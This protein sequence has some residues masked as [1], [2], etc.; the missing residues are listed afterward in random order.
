MV[1]YP[2]SPDLVLLA[3]AEENGE[4]AIV[5]LDARPGSAPPETLDTG[6]EGAHVI[7]ASR[8]AG[9]LVATVTAGGATRLLLVRQGQADIELARINAHLDRV[10]HPEHRQVTYMLNDP[11]NRLAPRQ[12]EGCVML[13]PDYDAGKS[14][15]LL[16]D[17]Y[18]TGTGGTC[19]TLK[20]LPQ[21]AAVTADLWAARGFIYIRPAF[22]LDLIR[23]A[24]GPV[25]AMGN[26][27]DQTVDALVAQGYGDPDR[28]VLYG[29]SQ[30]GLLSLVT[31]T[32]TRKP[33][34]VIS[35]NGWADFFSHYFGARGLMRYFHLDQNGGD[36]RWRYEC[37][38]EGPSHYCP[39]GLR[40]S[41][42]DDPAAYARTSPVANAR[43]I[44]APVLLV[45]SDFDYFDMAQY[46]E[47]FGALYRAGKEAVYVRYWGEGHGPSSPANIRDLWQR[48]DAFLTGAGL[49]EN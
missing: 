6:Q 22:P 42:L 3:G 33:A 48:F 1:R 32:Q 40:D 20:D 12:T 44:T 38:M 7:D 26:V 27:F 35:M 8:A 47:M 34:A 29:F 41:A 36:N 45:H 2:L 24:D 15:P 4:T 5:F 18:P 46:D 37:E 19:R 30:G 28:V 11:E 43:N 13:P 23:T 10:R 49:M 16:V 39:F 14:Y 25:A 17:V 31:A 21:P 9:S